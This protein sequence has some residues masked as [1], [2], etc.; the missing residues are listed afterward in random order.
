M[1]VAL[2]TSEF[3]PMRAAAAARAGPW[4]EVMAEGRHDVVVLTSKEGTG[5]PRQSLGVEV[6]PFGA[7]SNRAGLAKRFWQEVRLGMDLARRLREMRPRPDVSVITSP[8]FFMACLCA[9]AARKSRIPYLFDAR[10]RY[11]QVLF[12]LGV[13]A[14]GGFSGRILRIWERD[15]YAGAGLVTTVTKGLR[16]DLGEVVGRDKVELVPNGFDGAAFTEEH[17]RVP[18]RERFTVVYHGRLGRFYE[19]EALRHL[20][21]ETAKLDPEVSF[22]LAGDLADARASG[23]WGEAEFRSELSLEK[24][25]ELLGSCHLGVC[26]LKETEAMRKALPAKVFDFLG[27]GL[28]VLASPTGE[29]SAFLEERGAGLTFERADPAALAAAVVSLKND[30]ARWEGMAARAA[31]LRTELDRRK[32]V[33]RFVG[34]LEKM[35]ERR[36][37]VS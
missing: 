34:L 11:P 7:P 10:D 4:A 15:V 18:K 31:G 32:Q 2:V 24:L 21:T 22:V 35:L 8:P 12:D 1:K 17:L 3:P 30:P 33:E 14:P 23:D 27:A 6:S 9:R 13:L 36:N 26:L 29:L 28:P 37:R 5:S 19:V 20:V 16:R 25:A